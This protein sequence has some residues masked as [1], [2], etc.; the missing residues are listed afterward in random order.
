MSIPPGSTAPPSP[1]PPPGTAFFGNEACRDHDVDTMYS[2]ENTWVFVLMFIQ[3]AILPLGFYYRAQGRGVQSN[4]RLTMKGYSLIGSC[5][6]IILLCTLGMSDV[7]HAPRRMNPFDSR[8]ISGIWLILL[9]L[10]LFV[11]DFASTVGSNVCCRCLSDETQYLLGK[12]WDLCFCG[13]GSLAL[14]V[15]SMWAAIGYHEVNTDIGHLVPSMGFISYAGLLLYNSSTDRKMSLAFQRAEAYMWISWGA[16]FDIYFTLLQVG[17][18]GW[19]IGEQHLYQ[20]LMYIWT[21]AT[22][23]FMARLNFRTGFPMFTLCFQMGIMMTMHLQ[24]CPLLSMMHQATGM[25]FCVAGLFRLFDRIL[26]A[27]FFMMMAGSAFLFS[28]NASVYFA[29]QH[30]DNMSYVF[31]VMVIGGTWWTYMAWMFIDEWYFPDQFR[32]ERYTPVHAATNGISGDEEDGVA[33]VTVVK[34]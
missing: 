19:T 28:N 20:A 33:M 31:A 15:T 6:I 32:A 14:T 12:F 9:P 2:Y 13:I 3:A 16:F 10:Y 34:G 8:L 18:N 30:F 5:W 4:A 27:S 26:E 29:D 25:F 22:A 17:F 1:P 23:L 11:R 7:N 21:G 24:Y